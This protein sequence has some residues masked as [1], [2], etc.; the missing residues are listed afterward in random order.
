MIRVVEA[1]KAARIIVVCLA[2]Y[3]SV[4]QTHS[5]WA[6]ASVS[7]SEAAQ[8]RGSHFSSSTS[9]SFEVSA[10]HFQVLY[11]RA[12]SQPQIVIWLQHPSV[13]LFYWAVWADCSFVAWTKSEA[14]Q[15]WII[16]YESGARI[17]A[18]WSKQRPREW[19]MCLLGHFWPVPSLSLSPSRSVAISHFIFHSHTHKHWHS[20]ALLATR[21]ARRISWSA[22][23]CVCA[24][25]TSQKRDD[26]SLGR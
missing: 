22:R 4:T 8:T 10:V 13:R 6:A 9:Q 21:L 25:A 7:Q 12:F 20:H 26:I 11:T 16:A 2:W 15:F 14:S 1:P 24:S 19:N 5:C 18:T 3:E 23:V 17:I